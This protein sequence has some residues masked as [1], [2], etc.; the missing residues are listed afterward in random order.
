MTSSRPHG[1]LTG[2]GWSGGKLSGV[3]ITN[4]T[5]I[6]SIT[7]WS[8]AVVLRESSQACYRARNDPTWISSGIEYARL[9]LVDHMRRSWDLVTW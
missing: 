5:F 3:Y 2:R 7:E 6:H 4:I 8:M 9:V 1:S